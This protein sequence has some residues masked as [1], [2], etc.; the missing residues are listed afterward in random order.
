MQKYRKIKHWSHWKWTKRWNAKDVGKTPQ[1]QVLGLFNHDGLFANQDCKCIF[2]RCRS[3]VL[4]SFEATEEEQSD[5]PP[6]TSGRPRRAK[7]LDFSTMTVSL[8]IKIASVVSKDAE[9]SQD[10]ALKPLKMNKTM[11]RRR[12]RE[13]PAEPS[14]WTFQPWRSL[15]QSRLQV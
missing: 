1:S 9:V 10:T 13:D 15:R 8:P 11:K 5:E 7:F 2:Q 4:Y 6:K 12:R 3:S 14:F